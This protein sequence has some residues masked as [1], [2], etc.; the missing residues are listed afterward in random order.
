MEGLEEKVFKGGIE[1]I[2]KYHVPFILIEFTKD[3]LKFHGTDPE[4]FLQLFADNGYKFGI[5][6]FFEEKYYSV[7]KI[8]KIC[9]FQINLYIVHS[10]I[11]E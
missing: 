7:K 9:N 10:N 4:Q 8:L 11:L 5:S 2:T 3:A 6:S 1:L